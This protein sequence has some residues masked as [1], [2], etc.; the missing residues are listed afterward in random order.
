M[1]EA[2]TSKNLIAIEQASDLIALSGADR[3]FLAP[4]N[5]DQLAEL[6][7]K[8]PEARLIGGGTDLCLELTQALRNIDVLISTGLVDDMKVVTEDER[9]VTIGGATSY[10]AAES[11]LVNAYPDMQELLERLGSKQIRNRGTLG[12]NIGN[13]SP[14]ADLP[15]VLIV[16][17]AQLILRKGQQRRIVAVEDFYTSYK[18]TF[19]QAS[20]LSSRL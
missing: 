6:L 19:L 18:K 4:T 8:H 7:L 17:Q 2:T 13:A 16:L 11:V 10:A 12:G 1:S 20:S 15:P 9:S 3:Q 14:I 5:T